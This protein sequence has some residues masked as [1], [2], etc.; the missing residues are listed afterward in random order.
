[1][2]I[3]KHV[4]KIEALQRSSALFLDCPAQVWH[5]CSSEYFLEEN[6][7]SGCVE[8]GSYAV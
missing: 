3:I 6:K 5:R 1:M 4:I 8:D 7:W 2:E